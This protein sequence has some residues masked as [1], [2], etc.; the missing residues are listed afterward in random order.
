M[1]RHDTNTEPNGYS[2]KV[3]SDVA[4]RPEDRLK[5][6]FP[7][8][9]NPGYGCYIMPTGG[10]NRGKPTMGSRKQQGYIYLS[11][12][13][14]DGDMALIGLPFRVELSPF[15]KY[16]QGLLIPMMRGKERGKEKK[17]PTKNAE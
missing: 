4:Y 3:L 14:H 8:A 2:R 1:T 6:P 15:K 13:P 5:P 9:L 16:N 17:G 12:Q 7:A 11:A 10:R